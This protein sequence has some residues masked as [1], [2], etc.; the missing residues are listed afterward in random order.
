MP[1]SV[2]NVFV[3]EIICSLYS[4]IKSIITKKYLS[5]GHHSG[6]NW[7]HFWDAKICTYTLS[8]HCWVT[9][10][11]NLSLLAAPG[12]N[13]TLRQAKQIVNIKIIL[14]VSFHLICWTWQVIILLN[15][16]EILISLCLPI[17]QKCR[18]LVTTLFDYVAAETG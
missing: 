6:W 16:A 9:L 13:K 14:S 1:Q 3:A 11:L 10:S 15:F 18:F 5:Q 7:V 4:I 12:R 17:D 2:I 8:I